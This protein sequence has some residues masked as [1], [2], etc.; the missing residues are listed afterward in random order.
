M[1]RNPDMPRNG[2]AQNIIRVKVHLTAK[3]IDAPHINI[4]PIMIKLPIFYPMAR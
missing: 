4:A 3:A 2:I 1:K